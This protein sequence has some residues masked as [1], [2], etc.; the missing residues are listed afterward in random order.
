MEI[1]CNLWKFTAFLCTAFCASLGQYPINMNFQSTPLLDDKAVTV[2]AKEGSK[3]ELP[4]PIINKIDEDIVSWLKQTTSTIFDGKMIAKEYP[5]FEIMIK[6]GSRSVEWNLVINNVTTSDAAMYQCMVQT[7]PPQMKQVKLQVL[8]PAG[9][10]KNKIKDQYSFEEGNRLLNVTCPVR[11]EPAPTVQWYRFKTNNDTIPEVKDLIATGEHLI[12]KNPSRHDGG[13]YRC[14]ANNSAGA[15]MYEVYIKALY[16]PMIK[17]GTEKVV[18]KKNAT[19]VLRCEVEGYPASYIEWLSRSSVINDT[20][21]Y[22]IRIH[23]ESET[24][25]LTELFIDDAQIADEGEYMCVANNMYGQDRAQVLMQVNEHTSVT[26]ATKTHLTHPTNPT[27]QTSTVLPEHIEEVISAAMDTGQHL[28][29]TLQFG[30]T[31]ADPVKTTT[32]KNDSPWIEESKSG[33]STKE[34]AVLNFYLLI[35]L[36]A[37]IL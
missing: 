37:T 4:C 3:A 26:V 18:V 1:S 5:R 17:T 25:Q 23:F 11:G 7:F 13:I 36:I 30:T 6:N 15:D 9:I 8:A 27:T 32:P 33:C 20:S 10:D 16:K 14:E 24:H 34:N 35:F 31:F 22:K 28:P 12:I 19:A 29:I 2:T 21:K